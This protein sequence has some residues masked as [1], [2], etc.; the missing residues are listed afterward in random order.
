MKPLIS[1]LLTLFS[2][3]ALANSVGF[4]QFEL[5]DEPNRPLHVTLWYPTT[6]NAPATLVADNIAFEGTRVVKEAKVMS[7]KHPLVLLSHGYRGSWRNLNWLAHKLVQEGYIVA[8]P[9][10][11]GTTTFDHSPSQSSQW[12]QRPRDL[13]RVLNYLEGNAVWKES[14]ASDDVTAI[15]HSLGGWSVAQLGGAQFDRSAFNTQCKIHPN[16]RT[17]GLAKE[18]GLD[19]EQDGEPESNDLAD[20]R[21]KRVV[22]LDLGLA[23]SFSTT[24]LNEIQ[25]PSLIL[26]AG[27]D[28]GD[29]P[30]AMESGYLA[31]HIPLENRRYK[32]FEKA[33]HFSFMQLCKSNAIAILEEEVPGDGVICKDGIGSDRR[34]LH[35][36]IYEDI[37]RFIRD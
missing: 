11:P 29:L 4:T 33:T 37:A 31:E 9:D 19:A 21:I 18:L 32:V 10:H 35:E 12:W 14:I 27:I 26:A 15:G 25:Q 23:R 34:A 1:L 20:H 24:S 8:A 5:G 30:Q 36:A 3:N 22:I 17:C 6:D 28:I 13:I 16:P 7:A 2:L